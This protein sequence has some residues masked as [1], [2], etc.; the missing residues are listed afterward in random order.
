M[1][2]LQSRYTIDI[3]SV[4]MLMLSAIFLLL[5]LLCGV[6]GDGATQCIGGANSKT[7]FCGCQLQGKGEAVMNI[8]LDFVVTK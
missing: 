8:S 4:S 2:S 3:G 1:I 5:P 6:Y 7:S